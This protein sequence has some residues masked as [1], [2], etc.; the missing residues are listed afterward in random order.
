M[1]SSCWPSLLNP[2]REALSGQKPVLGGSKLNSKF[3]LRSWTSLIA[4][5]H[6][7]EMN[8]CNCRRGFEALSSPFCCDTNTSQ[9]RTA[10]CTSSFGT[11]FWVWRRENFSF[12]LSTSTLPRASVLHTG[13]APSTTLRPAPPQ[14]LLPT[15]WEDVGGGIWLL[16]LGSV[17][18]DWDQTTLGE[19]VSKL[20]N[21]VGSS[22]IVTP[23]LISHC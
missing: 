9:P 14:L 2:S 10:T 11:N 4:H 19:G 20:C 23:A 3:F 16:L 21:G 12:P 5:Q 1:W 13:S 8:G 7:R 15:R 22:Q 18:G 6:C 17:V